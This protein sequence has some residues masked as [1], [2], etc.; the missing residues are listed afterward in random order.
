MCGGQPGFAPLRSLGFFLTGF[1]GLSACLGADLRGDRRFILCS[2]HHSKPP[3]LEP[4]AAGIS[5]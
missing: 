2:S 5:A 1:G 3:G 4:Y